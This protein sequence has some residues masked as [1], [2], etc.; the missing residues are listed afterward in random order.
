MT[1]GPR[2]PRTTRPFERRGSRG[3]AAT[4]CR[5]LLAAVRN[6]NPRYTNDERFVCSS[7]PSWPKRTTAT[8]STT[9]TTPLVASPSILSRPVS[10]RLLL[11]PHPS[12]ECPHTTKRK[13]RSNRG[14]KQLRFALRGAD[15]GV[16]EVD[17]VAGG[18]EGARE[19]GGAQ[20]RSQMA[21]LAEL[22]G[23]VQGQRRRG[24]CA[25]VRVF[26]GVGRLVQLGPR[27]RGPRAAQGFPAHQAGM[28]RR[29]H[30]DCLPRILGIAR[31][32]SPFPLC[33]GADHDSCYYVAAREQARRA[34]KALRGI[35]RLQA[36]VRGRRVRKQ[37]AV[38]LKCMHALLRVQERAR[39]RRARSSSDGHG[40]QGQDALNGCASSTKDAM[41]YGTLNTQD[42]TCFFS[43][44]Q[45]TQ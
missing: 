41:V 13:L 37:L 23:H 14:S 45:S 19:G 28:G 33:S 11:P 10:P 15:G 26:F 4:F 5:L 40:S 35:V 20:G 6:L 39:E 31:I 17:Q 21:S 3:P 43:C 2:A 30:P 24:Q 36:L 42:I 44:C 1:Y 12:A 29:P 16:G 7:P 27:R 18:P 38:T 32:P 8:S 9:P 25:G 22:V 34:L